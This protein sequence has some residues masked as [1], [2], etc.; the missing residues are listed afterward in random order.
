MQAPQSPE[1][2]QKE[3]Q[4]FSQKNKPPL[5]SFPVYQN[6]P[7]NRNIRK[8]VGFRNFIGSEE[9]PRTVNPS[10]QRSLYERLISG[11]AWNAFCV[12]ESRD[13]SRDG[14]LIS[15][16][17][18]NMTTSFTRDLLQYLSTFHRERSGNESPLHPSNLAIVPGNQFSGPWGGLSEMDT[19][20]ISLPLIR[21]V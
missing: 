13:S 2:S 10:A 15:P 19:L 11:Q 1:N 18:P 4:G 21:T 9:V 8:M 14:R 12:P 3:F 17:P 7:S 5:S 20:Q 16:L 6:S